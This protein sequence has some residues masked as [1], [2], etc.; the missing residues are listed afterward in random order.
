MLADQPALF[1]ALSDCTRYL[2][3][4]WRT[5]EQYVLDTFA[6]RDI[7]LL[8]EDHAIRHN[9]LLVQRLIPLLPAVGVFT[10]VSYTHLDVYKRQAPACAT[11][12]A[13]SGCSRRGR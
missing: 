2:R 5:P 12:R 8:A 9:L 6:R 1:N 4:Q 3:D 13:D 11:G 10:P 7:V